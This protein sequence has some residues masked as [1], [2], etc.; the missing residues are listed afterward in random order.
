MKTIDYTKYKGRKCKNCDNRATFN[1]VSC[2][3]CLSK[4]E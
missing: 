3:E 2:R 4:Y 1:D